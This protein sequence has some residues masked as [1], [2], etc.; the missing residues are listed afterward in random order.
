MGCRVSQSDSRF[1]HSYIPD[2]RRQR[3]NI[4][5][6]HQGPALAE[7]TG[8]RWRSPMSLS[9]V[10]SPA[11]SA[12]PC[13]SS[14]P[15]LATLIWRKSRANGGRG[16]LCIAPDLMVFLRVRR[17]EPVIKSSVLS[18]GGF[19]SADDT[20]AQHKGKNGICTQIGNDRFTFFATPWSRSRANFLSLLRAMCWATR[21]LPTCTGGTCPASSSSASWKAIPNGSSPTRRLGTPTWITWALP[22]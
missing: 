4:S 5:S 14:F 8:S 7:E 10:A 3:G 12:V 1:H 13:A 19:S 21:H 11:R 15:P 16:E 2:I 20:G 6:N 9:S 22:A 17:L 18:H